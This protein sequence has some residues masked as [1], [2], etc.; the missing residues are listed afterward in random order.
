MGR[1]PFQEYRELV[2]LSKQSLTL[3]TIA[4]RLGR[5]SKSVLKAA[6]RLGVSIKGRKAETQKKK[7][8]VPAPKDRQ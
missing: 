1:W 5:P 4:A 7:R 8:A 2:A 6:A 3:E